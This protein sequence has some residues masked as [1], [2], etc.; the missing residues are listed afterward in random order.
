MTPDQLSD[1]SEREWL[2]GL[3]YED[4][5]PDS[6]AYEKSDCED[7]DGT[8]LVWESC[9]CNDCEYD[10]KHSRWIACASCSVETDEEEAR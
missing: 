8:R 9:A 7:C 3:R 5:F 10:A 6:G 1:H 4:K 2:E